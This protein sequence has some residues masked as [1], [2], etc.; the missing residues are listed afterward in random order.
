MITEYNPFSRNPLYSGATCS[1]YLE[2]ILLSKHAH[3]TVKLFARKLLD[4]QIIQ[5]SG[6]PLKDFSGIRFLDRFVFKNPKKRADTEQEDGVKKVKGSHPKFA[7]RKNYTAKGMRSIPINS[8]SYLNEDASKIPVDEKFLYDFLRK[9][10]EAQASDDEDSDVDSVT[11]EDFNQYLDNLTGTSK[12]AESDEEI[13]YLAE[14]EAAKQKRPKKADDHDNDN[15]DLGSDDDDADL[16]DVEEGGSDGELNISADEDEPALSGEEDELL[17]EDDDEDDDMIDVPGKKK[18]KS[19]MKLKGKDDLSSLFASAEEFSTLL[20]ETATNKK[21]GS[22]Q[23][24]S[25]T[26]N[27]SVKQLAWEEK[28]DR[29]IKGYNKNILGKKSKGKFNKP[30][31]K[32]ADKQSFQK[33]GKRKG[34]KPEGPGGKRKKMK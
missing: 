26:D 18:G 29:W 4:D 5:Y 24:V 7:V 9:R 16:D 32:M 34:G 23:A 8:S 10:R 30:K 21:Q 11:S 19:K 17:L 28:R 33:G 2:L 15:D 6:D 1:A 3:P 12:T 14:M 22:S 25:N 31:G 27:A 20:E 13:D